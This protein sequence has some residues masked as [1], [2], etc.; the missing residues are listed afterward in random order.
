MKK[1][2]EIF[3]NLYRNVRL[4]SVNKNA[5]PYTLPEVTPADLYNIR[6]IVNSEIDN[7]V[8]DCRLGYITQ[9]EL[10]DELDTLMVIINSL[11][12]DK[13]NRPQDRTYRAFA[14]DTELKKETIVTVKAY[15]KKD[16][17]IIMRKNGYKPNVKKCKESQLFNYIMNVGGPDYLDWSLK[18]IPDE[19]LKGITKTY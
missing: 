5:T 7:A 18:R 9:Q 16:A 10:K 14:Y 15:T 11:N 6:K 8:T 13:P 3:R 17:L 4:T 19:Y 1:A 2:M 12:S